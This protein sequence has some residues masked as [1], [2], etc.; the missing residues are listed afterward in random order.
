MTNNTVI[1][2]EANDIQGGGAYVPDLSL[3]DIVLTGALSATYA[4]T[5]DATNGTSGWSATNTE[6][7]TATSN[8]TSDHVGNYTLTV[9]DIN[10]CQA[11]DI[12]AVTSNTPNVSSSSWTSGDGAFAECANTTSAEEQYT[13][14]AGNLTGDLTVTPPSGFEISLTSGA[15]FT[16]SSITI[17]QADAEAGD[18]LYVRMA[19]AGSSPSNGNISISGGGLSS[20]HTVALSGVITATPN[21]GTLS[22]TE[23]I[24]SDGSTTFT[25]DGDSGGAWT[26]ATTGVATINIST[27]AV[28]PVAAGSSVIT[29]T[30][31]GTGGCSNATATR[32]VTVTAAPNAGTLSGTESACIGGS[33]VTFTSDGDA[34][35][36]W[37]SATT[38]VATINS[39]TGAITPIS[40][41]SSV[42]TYTVTGTGGCSDATATRTATVNT[43]PSV[44]AGSDVSASSG[45]SVALDATVSGNITGTDLFTEANSETANYGTSATNLSDPNWSATGSGWKGESN[46]TTSSDTGPSAPQDGDDYMYLETSNTTSDYLTSGSISGSNINI[47]F[48]YHMYGSTIGTLKL[49]SYD[50]S[51]W[52]D[53][54]TIT[55]QQHASSATAWTLASVDLSAYTVTQLRFYGTATGDYFGDIALDN[56]NVSKGN[57]VYAWTTD[58]S[59]G[60]SGWSATNT[61]DITVT[62]SADGTHAGD[63]TLAVTDANGCQASDVV[64]VTVT[65]P[66]ISSSGSLSTFSACSGI[67]SS[68]Q[69]FSVSGTN[70]QA[71]LIVTPPSGYEVSTSSGSGFGSSVSL[72]PSTG[73]V[74]STTIYVRT[75]T[76]AS[77]SDGGNIACTSTN[78]S[79]VNVTTGSATINSSPTVTVSISESSGIAN[80]DGTVCNGSSVTLSGGGASSYTWDNSISNGS[81][82]TASSTTT[83]TVTGTDGSGCQNTAQQ[84]ITVNTLPTVSA[85][86]DISVDLGNAIALDAT[87]SNHGDGSNTVFSE[88]FQSESTGDVTSSASTSIMYQSGNQC[89]TNIWEVTSSGN[90]NVNCS[91]CSG[92]W[93]YIYENDCNQDDY[94]WTDAF[95]PSSSTIN[96]SF[97]Y[98]FNHYSSGANGFY[99][100]LYN[101]TDGANVS[102]LISN[103]S[104]DANTSYSSSVSLTGTNSVNDS[105]R[106]KFRYKGNDDWGASV[107][108]ILVTET[109]SPTYAWTTD[110]TNGNTGWSATNTVDITVTN[111]AIADHA[112]DYTLTVTHGL[113]GCQN[114]DVVTVTTSTPTITTSGTL[115]TFTACASANSAEQ[116]FT[117]SGSN[118][119]N[120]IVVTPPSGYEVSTT[121]GSSFASSVTLSQS[122][123]TVNSTTIYVRTTTGASNADG[124]NIASTSTGATTVNV[125]T[126]SATIVTAPNAGTLSGNSA[127]NVGSAITLSSNGDAGGT[128]TSDNTSAATINSSS[129]AVAAVAIGNAVMTYTVSA[130]PCSDATATKTINITN[131]FLSSGSSSNWSSTSAWGGGVVPVTSGGVSPDVTISHD[132]TVDA[133]TNTLGT[134]TVDNSMT[135]TVA[136]GNTVTISGAS[137]VNGTISVTG[138][139]DANGTFDGTSGTVTINANGTLAVAGT[140]TDLGTFTN[141][142]TFAMDGSGT[143]TIPGN[144]AKGTLELANSGANYVISGGDVTC[145]T[146][147]T[148][149]QIKGKLDFDDTSTDLIIDNTNSTKLTL[150]STTTFEDAVDGSHIRS[151]GN[152]ISVDFSKTINVNTELTI[153]I[154]PD[155]SNREIGINPN[156]SPA[157]VYTV[158]YKTGTPV[159]LSAAYPAHGVPVNGAG[160]TSV[161]NHYYYDVDPSVDIDTYITL[162]FVGLDDTPSAGDRYL[163]HWDDQGNGVGDDDTWDVMT[164]SGT[165]S[166]TVTALATS[167]S[168]FGSGSGGGAALPIDLVSFD[169]NCVNE[170]IEL[171]FVVA[172]QINNDYFTIER[173]L[174]NKNWSF[175]TEIDGVEGGNTSTQ[176]TYKWMDNS[177]YKGQS[178][179][180]LT[181]VDYDGE[182]KTFEPI[183]NN[184]NDYTDNVYSAYPNPTKENLMIDIELDNYQGDNVKL[185]LMDING[186]IV[187]D[188]PIVLEKGFNHLEVNLKELPKGV[189]MMQFKGVLSHIKE[190]RIIK[191]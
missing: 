172:S 15:S 134:L 176:M 68:E 115:S 29:Y 65:T 71:N 173:S 150:Y 24:C 72:T 61:V 31:T 111:S 26:S 97:D 96:V 157:T 82:F 181:Q 46:S 75:T 80:N 148:E 43:A 160:I 89:G 33:S 188:E 53:R 124:G 59:N 163:L 186:K 73:T 103:T 147:G 128:W 164:T 102:T 52:T 95:S 166:G 78:A 129:A 98:R 85:G 44:N 187:K 37:T 122:G 30:I 70:L 140:I 139:Y 165:G 123:G 156:E 90:S 50:G 49:Q 162:G 60:T 179:Y 7:I 92:K 118:L 47:S 135:L 69:T 38:G 14:N 131:D 109:G 10:S 63:Y 99:V 113:N 101:Q 189:Y 170:E 42:M 106:L 55:G 178:Y 184:C 32:T 190:S 119:T 88:D 11:S 132:V 100:Y 107:D 110:A 168:P 169:A 94:L 133:S 86:S 45:G 67:V 143:K 40:A 3:D 39:G 48:Y 22:G 121:S 145:E 116:S 5:T 175:V 146:D 2:F 155:G 180:Q 127:L 185:L 104:T 57:P 151:T 28:S 183:V 36:A 66:T 51:S 54:W 149:Y 87:V 12:V 64:A 154:G 79:T 108:N 83:Y 35:G 144:T 93:I 23:G 13:I 81:A 76:G 34:G 174:D 117:A 177:A 41:G 84:T 158:Q 77:N 159:A 136:T 167:F 91:S 25:S 125:A 161:N 138:T 171:E 17:P 20:A 1:Q 19:S 130:S 9:T 120:D 105:Y 6:D 191:N 153:P 8:A 56:I 141:N 114:T 112:G 152:D 16:T 58:A 182:Y 74:S 18:I 126:G 142:G 4:W 62:A 21:A 137:D 27:G